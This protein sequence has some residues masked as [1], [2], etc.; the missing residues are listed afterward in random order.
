LGPAIG[1]SQAPEDLL[2]W[3]IMVGTVL[4]TIW[5]I[6]TF[7]FRLVSW[8]VEFLGRVTGLVL[9][10]VLMVL[11]VALGAGPLFLIGIPLFLIGL[12]LTLRCLG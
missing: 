7:P 3:W 6:F 12:I 4:G 1:I 8:I 10:F 9:G 5:A 11:G 2:G